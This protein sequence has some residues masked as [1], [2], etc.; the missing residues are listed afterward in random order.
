MRGPCPIA[1]I[2]EV[3]DMSGPA[4][5]Y[6]VKIMVARSLDGRGER[7][8]QNLGDHHP[9]EPGIPIEFLIFSYWFNQI[10]AKNISNF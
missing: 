8:R 7:S 3:L 2:R 4:A 6:R 5:A 9:A 1:P 10:R